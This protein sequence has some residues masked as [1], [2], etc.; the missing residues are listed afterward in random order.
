MVIL[1]LVA[2]VMGLSGATVLTLAAPFTGALLLYAL[3]RFVRLFTDSPWAP[4]LALPAVLLLWGPNVTAF[5]GF[6][7]L[8]GL[9]LL[10]PY[11][12]T[13]AMA[14]MLLCWVA[15]KTAIDSRPCCAGWPSTRSA[16]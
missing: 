15:T 12:S 6:L 16:L 10:T 14:L 1:A 2:K 7:A 13:V 4:V 8:R 5:S 3:G 11:P 9:P